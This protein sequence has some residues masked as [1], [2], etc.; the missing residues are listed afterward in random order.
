MIETL[1]NIGFVLF[2]LFIFWLGWV[3]KPVRVVSQIV[4]P[5]RP[6]MQMFLR[7]HYG[8]TGPIDGRIEGGSNKA[9]ERYEK[10]DINKYSV[11]LIDRMG[12]INGGTK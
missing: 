5:V 2:L 6:T 1:K 10:D 3:I 4:Y 12:G 7:E 9:W 8:Y 11:D